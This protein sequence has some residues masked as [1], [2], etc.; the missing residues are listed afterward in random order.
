VDWRRLRLAAQLK[1]AVEQVEVLIAA[2][3]SA[4]GAV[5]ESPWPETT[6]KASIVDYFKTLAS[7]G[8]IP[9]NLL[10][11]SWRR[12]ADN[13]FSLVRSYETDASRMEKSVKRLLGAIDADLRGATPTELPVSGTLFQY[14]VSVVA[15]EDTEGDLSRFTV[16]PSRELTD[17][18]NV[19]NLPRPFVF[20][21]QSVV[22]PA[23][24]QGTL[25]QAETG[26]SE[27]QTDEEIEDARLS[28]DLDDARQRRPARTAEAAPAVRSKPPASMKS[29]ATK[30]PAAKK[31]AATKPRSGRNQAAS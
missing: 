12:F 30:K 22:Q 26:P 18:Y 2:F 28:E 6:A 10:P 7:D 15:R 31:P 14:V 29:G 13:V 1:A 27:P 3:D 11:S 16:V 21:G 20:D 17:F 9:D 8:L 19:K 25:S 24:A 4:S 5:Q 23:S